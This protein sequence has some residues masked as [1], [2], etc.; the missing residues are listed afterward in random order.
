M[1]VANLGTVGEE[2]G[3]LVVELDGLGVEID[4][5]RPVASGEGFVAL[6]FK[7]DG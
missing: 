3:L 6:V 7:V 5:G 2:S 1:G 4:G